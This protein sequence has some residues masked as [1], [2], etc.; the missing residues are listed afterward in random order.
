MPHAEPKG[1][2]VIA[3][4]SR[5]TILKP[6]AD[7]DPLSSLVAAKLPSSPNKALEDSCPVV[8][9]PCSSLLAR[10]LV[11]RKGQMIPFAHDSSF[12]RL[13]SVDVSNGP[14]PRP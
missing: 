4:T 10:D 14:I 11:Q 2:P 13:S 9:T 12:L 5:A 7:S 1:V 8:L 6:Q 3:A